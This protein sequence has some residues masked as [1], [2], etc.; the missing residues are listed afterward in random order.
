MLTINPVNQNNK[1]AFEA[2]L[3]IKKLNNS[4]PFSNQELK[5]IEDIFERNTKNISGE[6]ELVSSKR[7]KINSVYNTERF[8]EM[9]FKNKNYEDFIKGYMPNI[10]KNVE[11]FAKQVSQFLEVFKTRENNVSKLKDIQSA[12]C[13]GT[14]Q[15]LKSMGMTYSNSAIKY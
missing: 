10:S 14:D 3:R 9:N 8:W 6:L 2:S 11:S 1:T 12:L 4:L 15:K 13:F 7:L 5:T